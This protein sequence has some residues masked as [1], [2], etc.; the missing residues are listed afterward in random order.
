MMK[1]I[2]FNECL[3]F[4]RTSGGKKNMSEQM[5]LKAKLGLD[6][7]KHTRNHISKIKPGMK[8]MPA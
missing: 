3:L 4:S 5:G 6:V 7:F 8:K 2:K 1:Y